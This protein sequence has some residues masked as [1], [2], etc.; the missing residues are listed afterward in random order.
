[1]PSKIAS[2]ILLAAF[3]VRLQALPDDNTD[4]NTGGGCAKANSYV[5]TRFSNHQTTPANLP[6]EL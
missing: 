5:R 6:T 3:A 1:M 4:D 2:L